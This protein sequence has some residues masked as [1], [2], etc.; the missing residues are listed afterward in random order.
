[1]ELELNPDN[2]TAIIRGLTPEILGALKPTDLTPLIDRIAALE[3][4]Q[5]IGVYN[6]LLAP[7]TIKVLSISNSQIGNAQGGYTTADIFASLANAVSKQAVWVPLTADGTSLEQRWAEG[8]T[9]TTPRGIINSGGLSNVILQELSNRP[10]LDSALFFQYVRLFVSAIRDKN[11]ACNIFLYGNWS[12]NDVTDYQAAMTTM[13]TNYKTICTEL[14]IK[15]IPCH[16]G[17]NILKQLYGW[18]SLNPYSDTRHPSLIGIYLNALI[19]LATIA[20]LNILNNSFVPNGISNSDASKI[21][22]AAQKALTYTIAN[23]YKQFTY[24]AVTI[25]EGTY[26][27]SDTHRATTIQIYTKNIAWNNGAN[28]IT[29]Q[30]GLNFYESSFAYP[31]IHQCAALIYQDPLSPI[32]ITGTETTPQLITGLDPTKPIRITV[33]DGNYANN[34]GTF[35]VCWR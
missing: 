19:S 2:K 5:L 29:T 11:P 25:K 16:I 18:T 6:V 26:L 17:W 23:P 14:G 34:T 27:S 8:T 1:M 24:S 7:E 33:N 12:W 9:P 21:K 10:L 22:D 3:A 31:S 4:K 13:D 15:L 35:D 32:E 28:N 30:S 20:N